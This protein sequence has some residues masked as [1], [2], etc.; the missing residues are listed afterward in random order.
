MAKPRNDLLD[1]LVYLT[2]RIFTCYL[3]CRPINTNLE[4]ARR[5]GS[6]MYW[7]DRRHRDRAIDNV[8]RAFPELSQKQAETLARKSMQQLVMLSVELMFTTRLVRI[9]TWRRYVD[10]DNFSQTMALLMERHQGLIMLTGH[11]GNWEILGYVLATLGFETSTVTRPLDNPYVSEYVLGVRAR[12][13]QRL[14]YKKGATS[15]LTDALDDHGVVCMV[16]DQDAGS[17]GIFVDFF[18]RKASAYKSIGLLAM[19]Y[20]VPV[21]VGYARRMG[22]QFHFR[23]ATQDII[24]PREWKEQPDPLR[25]ITQRYTT[26]IEDFV[27]EDPTQYLWTHRRWKSRPKGEAPEPA[28]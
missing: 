17:K 19:Q 18:G 7:L 2:L 23:V 22:E 9:D 11:Y 5:I 21:V 8:R 13:G 4:T 15:G 12:Q 1:R 10:I 14:V 25:Y 20:N 28:V 26:A 3:H 6:L 27:R 16:A 24:W